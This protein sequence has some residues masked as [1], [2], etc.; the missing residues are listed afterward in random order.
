MAYDTVIDVLD[1]YDKH[2]NYTHIEHAITFFMLIVLCL[3]NPEKEV[4]GKL[5]ILSRMFWEH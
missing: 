5:V 2:N 1:V 3:G 4:W